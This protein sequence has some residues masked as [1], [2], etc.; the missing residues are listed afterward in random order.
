MT[1]TFANKQI[2]KQTM[3]YDAFRP[4]LTGEYAGYE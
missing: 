4:H 2:P 3:K 1:P